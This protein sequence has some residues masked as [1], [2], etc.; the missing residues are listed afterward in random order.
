[1][2]THTL[3]KLERLKGHTKIRLLFD[4]GEKFK[5]FPLTVIYFFE[6]RKELADVSS[7]LKM[8]VAVGTRN[9]KK[10]VDRNLLKRRIR[11]AYRI[12]NTALK[13][14][15]MASPFELSLFYIYGD[16]QLHEYAHISTSIKKSLDKLQDILTNKMMKSY[17]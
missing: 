17:D 6:D 3:N 11:E 4:A 5:V 1:M 16:N 15:V 9:F 12:Q 14:Q 7:P 8:G 10:A 13:Q 2:P